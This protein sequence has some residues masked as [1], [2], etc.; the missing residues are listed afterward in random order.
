MKRRKLQ[1]VLANPV[2]H[3]GGFTLLEVLV[4]FMVGTLVLTVVLSGFSS[5]LVTLSRVD[6]LSTAALVAQS[7]LAE[8]GAQRPLEAGY[9]QGEDANNPDYR[10]EVN[11]SPLEWEYASELRSAG[12]VLFRVEATVIWE[13]AGRERT[14]SLVSLRS[15]TPAPI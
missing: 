7:R 12:S 3:Q 9:F 10:W 5:G 11:V 6:D 2:T 1:R 15:S 13:A 14:F 8:V 4:A